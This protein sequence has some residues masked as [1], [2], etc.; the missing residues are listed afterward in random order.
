MP[1]IES[2]TTTDSRLHHDPR[3]SDPAGPGM[4]DRLRD[5]RAKFILYFP[6]VVLGLWLALLLPTLLYF[7]ILSFSAYQ[8]HIA[9]KS[10]NSTDDRPISISE[11]LDLKLQSQSIQEDI[12]ARNALRA[13]L[14]ETVDSS[15]KLI[16][17]SY[18][19]LRNTYEGCR[20][21]IGRILQKSRDKGIDWKVAKCDVS[22]PFGWKDQIPEQDRTE[23]EGISQRYTLQSAAILKDISFFT[24]QLLS[25]LAAK[26]DLDLEIEGA[27]QK[28]AILFNSS[29]IKYVYDFIA[30]ADFFDPTR[31]ALPFFYLI[32]NFLIMPTDTLVL[33]I[34]ISMGTLGGA[35]Q[36]A[37]NFLSPEDLSNIDTYRIRYRYMF[38][39]PFLGSITALAIFILFKAGVLIASTNTNGNDAAALNPFF[40]SFLGIVS[41]LMANLALDT[42][43]KVGENWFKSGGSNNKAR[44]ANNLEAS[45]KSEAEKGEKRS[46]DD[47]KKELRGY[48]S[49][50][51]KILE[52][53]ISQAEPVPY[54]FQK[55]IAAFFRKHERDLFT[56]IPLQPEAGAV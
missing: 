22:N 20:Q 16:S 56:D 45:L 52:D 46:V 25:N 43:I 17:R 15:N 19:D 21:D 49:V 54:I 12:T 33:I 30:S 44:W 53:W 34:V 35:I 7:V 27:I 23:I 38:F 26:K 42:I 39:Q 18:I 3:P 32:P 40:V 41:G 37:R 50:P 28:K 4:R 36:I 10:V 1:D 11:I 55:L 5:A 13:Y 29:K 24:N 9:V 48:L 31:I 51:P 2:L 6:R 47:V 8:F 14:I